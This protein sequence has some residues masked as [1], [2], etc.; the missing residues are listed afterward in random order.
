MS[1]K[2][3]SNNTSKKRLLFEIKAIEEVIRLKTAAKEDCSFE[4]KLVDSYKRYL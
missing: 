1:D 3:K 2:D 4:K